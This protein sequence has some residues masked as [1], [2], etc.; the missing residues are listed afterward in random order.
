MNKFL[1][2]VFVI[3]VI[4]MAELPSIFGCDPQYLIT[5]TTTTDNPNSNQLW[6]P[7]NKKKKKEKKSKKRKLPREKGG[8]QKC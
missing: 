6:R 7:M 4:V 5:T 2:S 3:L 8:L 1:I